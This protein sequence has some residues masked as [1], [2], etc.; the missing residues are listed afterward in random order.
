VSVYSENVRLVASI[1]SPVF[2]EV[3][4]VYV[5]AAQQRV[6]ESRY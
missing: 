2:G 6:L 1:D 5:P 4:N 3:M